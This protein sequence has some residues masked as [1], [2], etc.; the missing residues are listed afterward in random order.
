MSD[1]VLTDM[2]ADGVRKAKE[3]FTTQT[4]VQQTFR[5]FGY[6]GAGKTTVVR[7]LIGEL[8]YDINDSKVKFA[9]FTG[10]AA[11]VMRKHGIPATTIHSLIYSVS[12]ATE[13]EIEEAKKLLAQRKEECIGLTGME[14]IIGDAAVQ[15][16]E[17]QLR[18]M[19]RPRFGLNE[20]SLIR[21]AD[22]VVLDEVSMVGPDMAR[23]L[24]S[25]EKPI[26]VLGDPGQ[27]PPIK[28]EG[29]FTMQDPD[30]MLTEIHRQAQESPIIR[31]ATMARL[32]QEIAHGRYSEAVF[33]MG[34]NQIG[35]THMLN[36]NQVIC[37]RNA[38]RYDLNNQ[39]RHAAG[40][41]WSNPLPDGPNEKLICLKND[42]DKGLINGMFL[43]MTESE[44]YKFDPTRSTRFQ[45]FVK[46]E[47][48]NI[49]GS[50]INKQLIYAGHF[51]DHIS[52]P[53]DR[54]LRKEEDYKIKKS[55]IEATFGYAITC[56]KAQ[57][58]QWENVIVIDDKLGR[59]R[60]DRAKWLYTAVT[61]AEYGL[62]ILE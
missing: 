55:L 62:L 17:Q 38:T 12:E 11:Y 30:V 52:S 51:L 13:A 35:P 27:L 58:S 33:K 39:M 43:A 7:N 9:A 46:T 49:V 26:L 8:G 6:A 61:R 1:I 24:L 16:I 60:I 47:E 21:D 48:D 14:R 20:E 23:D 36:A 50:G 56:H 18:D 31:L 29:A 15:A 37:G 28:S 22:L 54:E 59:T 57:G 5:I 42:N 40:H 53:E 4:A 3:W 2:Q 45:A 44:W 19:R 41:D 32:G 25:F 10:K 34:R